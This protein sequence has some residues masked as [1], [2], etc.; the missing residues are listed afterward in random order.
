MTFFWPA[1]E[2]TAAGGSGK[3]VS[4]ASAMLD[5]RVW[6]G[7]YAPERAYSAPVD[8]FLEAAL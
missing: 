8:Q 4:P 6:R 3:G 5:P 2:I 1:E 7:T